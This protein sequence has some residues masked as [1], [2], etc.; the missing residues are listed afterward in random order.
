MW[1]EPKDTKGALA[2]DVEDAPELGEVIETRQVLK[3]KI[4]ADLYDERYASTKRGL[5][6]R[7]LQMMAIGGAIGTGLF[8]GSGQ[9]LALG[10]PAFLFAS[11][12]IVS[13]LVFFIVTAISEVASYLPVHGGSMSY[14]GY[15]YVSS[16]LGFAM[17]YLYWYSLGILVPY[18]ITAASLVIGYWDPEGHISIG[19]WITVM[20]VVIV[21][22]NMLPVRFY[23]ESE[24]WFSSLK[25]ILLVG[26]LMLSFILF[27]G[28]GPNHQRLGFHYWKS[29]Y[30]AGR[31][32]IVDG[33]SGRFVALL[34]CVILSA[35]AFIFAPE[36]IV[37]GG[38]EMESPRRNIPRASRRFFYRLIFFY[39]MG[40]LSITVICPST[41]KELTDG[42]AGAGSS[43]FV[44]G[45]KNAGIPVLDH[46]VNAIVLTSAWSSGNS[47][48]YM[49]S[50]SLYS[51]AVANHAPSIFKTCNRWGLPY[52]A[53]AT[54]S[55]FSGLAYLSLGTS[56]SVVFN[57]FVSL[58]NTCGFISWACCA[59]IYF[60]F[61]KATKVQ[62]VERP[63]KSRLQP[64]GA[65]I[66]IVGAIF[67]AL[68]NGFTVFFPQEWSVSGF[69]TAY[70]GIPAFVVLYVGHRIVYRHE[71]WAWPSEAVDLQT[72]LEEVIAAEKPER[73]RD[74]WW[75]KLM[76]IIE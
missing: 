61:L 59:V 41:N 17:G 46:I 54:S 40:T 29:P 7:H 13:L 70:I 36:L 33:N 9:A 34:H 42:G 20:L 47:F 55:L 12:I 25:V 75:K 23:G 2:P 15:R 73:I 30:T 74:T 69:F 64:W 11:Y 3:S 26:L 1:E 63:Y 67:L 37:I 31:T 44:I 48:L 22:L 53:V 56:S 18:E 66:A 21:G 4:E 27:W 52:V 14:Y 16:S 39:I 62:G 50:R 28:G 8:V 5:K 72:G 43:P 10:G 35:F 38:G 45:I 71:P 65:Y 58:T 19:V 24:F 32:Y 76:I 51:L 6:S 57:W 60:R 68:V 49:S